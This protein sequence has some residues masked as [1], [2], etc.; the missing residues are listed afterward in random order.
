MLYNLFDNHFSGLITRVEEEAVA[1]PK[2]G[3]VAAAAAVATNLGQVEAVVVEEAIDLHPHPLHPKQGL[4][5]SGTVS[6]YA[7][8]DNLVLDYLLF[9]K[10]LLNFSKKMRFSLS[11]RR[12]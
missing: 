11:H 2:A 5:Q 4:C 1:A 3:L 9:A 10:C 8:S 6:R 7:H 12:A